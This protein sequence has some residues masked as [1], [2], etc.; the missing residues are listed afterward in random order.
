[1]LRD[2]LGFH[3]EK[4]IDLVVFSGDLADRG[5]PEELELGRTLLLDPLMERLGL[6]PRQLILAAGNHDVSQAAIQAKDERHLL[7]RLTSR[8]QVDSL[9]DSPESLDREIGRLGNWNEFHRGFYGADLPPQP[10]P[11]SFVHRFVLEGHSVAIAALNSAWRSSGRLDRGRLLLG[12]RQVESALNAIADADVRLVVHHHPLGWLVPFDA[13]RAQA[14]FENRGV[15]VL[16]GHEHNPN[17]VARKSPHGEVLQLSTGSLYLHREFP[18]S[19]EIL[20]VDVEDRTVVAHFRRWQQMRGVFDKDLETAA[21]GS[22]RFDL[23]SAGRRENLGH[24]RFSAVI[25]SIAECALERMPEELTR[26]VAV[27]AIEDALVEPRFLEAPRGEAGLAATSTTRPPDSETSPLD[28]SEQA[29]GDPPITILAGPRQAGVS[30]GLLW[31]LTDRYRR[32]ISRMPA[33]IQARDSS[34]GTAK[35]GATL[36]KASAVFGHRQSDSRDPDLHLAIAD[37]EKAPQRKRERIIEFMLANPRHR[38]VIGCHEDWAGG[39]AARLEDAGAPFRLLRLAPFGSPQVRQMGRIANVAP[40]DVERIDETIQ[41]L[42]L[43]R[44]PPTAI[45]LLAVVA[46]QRDP[47]PDLNES[48]LLDGFVNFQLD[49]GPSEALRLAMG[50]R[51]RAHLLG[52]LA[53]AL[54]RRKDRSMATPE[55]EAFLADY[56]NG[57]KGLDRV[58]NKVLRGLISS[59]VLLER[60][61]RVSLQPAVL[62]LFMAHWMLEGPT[63]RLEVLDDCCGNG[64][65]IRHAAAL[66]LSD[67]EIL[68]TAKAHGR[69]AIEATA[70]FM[71]GKRVDELLEEIGSAGLWKA[72][73]LGEVLGL[74][75]SRRVVAAIDA[76]GDRIPS[77]LT[78]EGAKVD[79]RR[80]EAAVRLNGA[81]SLLSDVLARSELVDDVELKREAL[82]T[83]ISGWLQLAGLL[84]V[85][86]SGE[87]PLSGLTEFVAAR[88]GDRK[89]PPEESERILRSVLAVGALF[90]VTVCVQ[91][92]LGSQNLAAIV[93][94]CLDGERIESPAARC[95]AT[96]LRAHSGSAGWPHQLQALLEA[97]PASSLLRDATMAISAHLYRSSP[98]EPEVRELGPILVDSIIRVTDR[99]LLATRKRDRQRQNTTKWLQQIR[100]TYQRHPEGASH[101]LEASTAGPRVSQPA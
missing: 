84:I 3:A 1:M 20:D 59:S 24:P 60:N 64:D 91:G 53:H 46:A 22:K 37:F 8:E 66:R 7:D 93:E 47:E 96:W 76:Q 99:R 80:L 55:A 94:D 92:R 30:C 21:N 44:N 28:R 52:E 77:V 11:L 100:R 35:V 10:G 89:L 97:L 73:H 2:V 62:D 17:P 13:G 69:S 65:V 45:A 6:E 33:L 4:R 26:T 51:Q 27:N 29:A 5:T 15:I 16:S 43:P 87:G 23:P 40:A 79:G 58:A 49:N 12:A 78:G 57:K 34:F 54:Y 86:G 90:V 67:R 41:R 74:L 18:N 82:E 31:Q 48:A 85:E 19:F 98:Q 61:R 71:T 56:F 38:Y 25:R 9:L 50:T 75:P 68:A 101:G 88:L 72:E 95:L 36:A 83:A 63:H 39:I 14:E 42:R 70:P 81:V 32:D